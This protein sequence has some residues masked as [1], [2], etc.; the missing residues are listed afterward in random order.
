MDRP[1]FDQETDVLLLDEYI[2]EMDSYKRIVEDEKITDTELVEQTLNAWCEL[3]VGN[4]SGRCPPSRV[5][6]LPVP[7]GKGTDSSWSMWT[8]SSPHF[9]LRSTT[10][11][12]PIRQKATRPSSLPLRERDRHP[13]H[14]RPVVPLHQRAGL[15]PLRPG[16]PA[17]CLPYPAQSLAIQPP[18]ALPYPAH[19][20]F[21]LA[22]GEPFGGPQVSLRGPR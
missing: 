1:W 8:P 14:L 11:A 10:S 2:V 13:H 9:T 21:L 6:L 20:G 4:L 22:P 16:Q 19:R 15:L 5:G 17:R 3:P 7:E 18:G 12:T